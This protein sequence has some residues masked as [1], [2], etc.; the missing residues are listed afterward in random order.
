[1]SRKHL[2]KENCQVR[3]MSLG[4]HRD[5]CSN[6]KFHYKI[7]KADRWLFFFYKENIQKELWSS[8]KDHHQNE[9]VSSLLLGCEHPTDVLSELTAKQ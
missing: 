5:Y 6:E 8:S 1:M 2:P 9:M 4:S 7:H 3:R